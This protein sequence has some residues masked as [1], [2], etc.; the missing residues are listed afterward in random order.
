MPRFSFFISFISQSQEPVGEDSPIWPT[1]IPLRLDTLIKHEE[2]EYGSEAAV[3]HAAYFR[4]ARSFLEADSFEVMTQA[5]SRRLNRYVTAADIEQ[6]RIYLE[7]HGEFYHPSRI[8]A[9]IDQQQFSF[10]LNVAVSA[11]G[12]RLIEKEYQLLNRLNN[13]RAFHYLPQVYGFGQVAG[14]DGPRFAMFLG[15]WFEGYHEFHISMDPVDQKLKIRVWDDARGRYFLSDGQMRT[16]YA[17]AANI[18]TAYYDLES[19]EQIF[20]WHHAAGDFIV[21]TDNEK[22]Q[23][24]LVSV[25][26]YERILENQNNTGTGRVDLQRLLHA[27]M[28]FFINL[29]I[30]MRLDRLE[31]IGEMVW[32]DSVAVEAT[33]TGFLEALLM[34]EDVPSLPDS[35]LACFMAYLAS[36]NR[37]DLIDLTEALFR[38]FNPQMPG[39]AVIRKNLRAHAET[40]YASIQQILAIS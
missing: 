35:P 6:I 21:K 12:R 23:M 2:E 24:K 25:R 20:S 40:L 17:Q 39:L 15:Q 9:V 7:K 19:F 1:P 18:L 11:A 26:R 38:R 5:V 14:F 27:L 32:S 37:K 33:L 4:A 29:S 8:E 31:G 36:C 3:S 22:L 13:E 30:H 28:I 16:L 34:K 10:V